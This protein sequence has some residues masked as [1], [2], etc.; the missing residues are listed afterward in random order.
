MAATNRQ[1]GRCSRPA[2]DNLTLCQTCGDAVV[3]DLLSVPALWVD[4]QITRAGL[5]KVTAHRAGGRPAETPLPIRTAARGPKMPG[6]LFTARP[7][8]QGDTVLA[9][10]GNTVSTWA[11]LLAEHLAVDIPIGAPALVQLAANN[12]ARRR[13]P[14]NSTGHEPNRTTAVIEHRLAK[15]KRIRTVRTSRADADMLT[16]PVTV[17]EQAAVWLACHPLEVR[18]LAAAAE[19]ADDISQTLNRVRHIVDR[20][21]EPRPIGPCPDCKV[22]LREF[23]DDRGNLPTFTKC[24][25]CKTMHVVEN[26]MRKSLDDLRDRL[27]TVAEIVRVT[28]DFGSPVARA[29]IYRWSDDRLIE[30]RGWMH[31]DKTYGT[32]ITDHQIQRGDPQVFRLGDVLDVAADDEEGNAA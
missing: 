17:V 24:S 8:M 9:A 23:A 6:N 4:L 12:R 13:L 21:R 1:C 22:E 29:T 11:R 2:A 7:A 20:P 25:A 14:E 32:R 27:L 15:G 30:P 16:E 18:Q 3:A 19:L 31:A 28:H 10:L 26:V 5:G